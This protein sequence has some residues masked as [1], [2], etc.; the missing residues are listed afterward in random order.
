M[1]KSGKEKLGE[2]LE[3]ISMGRRELY[4]GVYASLVKVRAALTAVKDQP[5]TV[6]QQQDFDYLRSIVPSSNTSTEPDW[7]KLASELAGSSDNLRSYFEAVERL[8][9]SL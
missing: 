8:E 2:A 5:M 4:L 3:K 9:A 7:E 1:V 6:Q